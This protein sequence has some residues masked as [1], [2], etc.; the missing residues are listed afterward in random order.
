[1]GNNDTEPTPD[2]ES[3]R[4]DEATLTFQTVAKDEGNAAVPAR[5]Y[6][7]HYEARVSPIAD[8]VPTTS[9][10]NLDAVARFVPSA[11]GAYEFV[12]NAPGY[13]HV[14][15]RVTGLQAGEQRTIRI[16]FPTNWASS[17]KGATAG[18][19]G[20]QHADLI[21]DTEGTNWDSTGSAVEGKQVLVKLAGTHRIERV[22]VSG[23]LIPPQNRFTALRSFEVLACRAGTGP[24]PT[25]NPAVS[26]GFRQVVR[27]EDDAFPSAPPR[28]VAPDLILRTWAGT[29]TM[30]TH[31]L[32]RVLDNQCTGQTAFQGEQDED[33]TNQTDCRTGS[34]PLPPRDTEVHAAELQVQSSSP[35]VDGAAVVD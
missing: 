26:A 35:T 34:A 27:S 30:A 8:T 28:P 11:D 10:T 2:F 13:G 3:P 12:A 18:G 20:T 25:C 14:R 5:I 15:F 1:M 33:P 17:A 16:A 29:G 31:L 22:S 21:D 4:E 6:V 9:G 32:F 19:D 7:G 23:M 24:N